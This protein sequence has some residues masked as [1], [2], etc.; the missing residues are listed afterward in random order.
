M[1]NHHFGSSL[2]DLLKDEGILEEANEVAVRKVRDWV[3]H[4]TVVAIQDRWPGAKVVAVRVPAA[5]KEK[6]K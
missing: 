1:K 6:S 2:E 5:D 3:R 4:M